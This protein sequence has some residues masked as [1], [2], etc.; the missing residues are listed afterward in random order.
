MDWWIGSLRTAPQHIVAIRY[1]CEAF[2]TC[3]RVP[4]RRQPPS[5][6]TGTGLWADVSVHYIGQRGAYRAKTCSLS[7]ALSLS[8]LPR[9]LRPLLC[10]HL[11]PPPIPHALRSGLI[12]CVQGSEAL[13]HT[14][15]C[16]SNSDFARTTGGRKTLGPRDNN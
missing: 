4:P 10:I 15:L 6:G 16:H 2:F 3:G 7:L 11:H 14:S 1:S 12:E 5:A 9:P 8:S 13:A